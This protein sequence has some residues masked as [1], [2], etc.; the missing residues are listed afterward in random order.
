MWILWLHSKGEYWYLKLFERI[1][2]YV[3]N[4][5]EMILKKGI[6]TYL[7]YEIHVLQVI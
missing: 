6:T 1:S 3:L 5:F 7:I 2:Y 4:D